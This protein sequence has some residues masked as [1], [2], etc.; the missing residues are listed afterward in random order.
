MAIRRALGERSSFGWSGW[1][2][3]SMTVVGGQRLFGFDFDRLAV[4]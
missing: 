2:G 3:Q 4:G 1:I